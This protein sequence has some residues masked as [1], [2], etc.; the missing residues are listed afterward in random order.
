MTTG[1]KT[2][3]WHY[4]WRPLC[5][6]LSIL[7][8]LS[9]LCFCTWMPFIR[10]E[11]MNIISYF[12]FQRTYSTFLSK[13]CAHCLME[14]NTRGGG[15]RPGHLFM[16]ADVV[17]ALNDQGYFSP[18]WAHFATKWAN[19]SYWWEKIGI[20]FFKSSIFCFKMWIKIWLGVA[21]GRLPDLQSILQQILYQSERW[22]NM[23]LYR[24]WFA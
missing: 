11:L 24:Q 16:T 14:W 1:S 6:V 2:T 9:I 19:L 20:F 17:I 18:T 23:L 22:R 21:D 7:V 8:N 5:N 13:F 15:D 12:A 4:G 10:N 3:K